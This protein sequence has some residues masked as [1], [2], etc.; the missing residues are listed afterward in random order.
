MP[1]AMLPQPRCPMRFCRLQALH[2][3][4]DAT[5]LGGVESL[6]EWRRKYDDAV[7]LNV[8]RSIACGRLGAILV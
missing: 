6:I 8:E 5:S 7:R 3:F 2:F 1:S 4:R